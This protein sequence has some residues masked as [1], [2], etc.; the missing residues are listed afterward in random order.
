MNNTKNINSNLDQKN[1]DKLLRFLRVRRPII[2][3]ALKQNEQNIFI[4]YAV[5]DDLEK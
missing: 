2:E 3:N 4:D 1:N 5:M